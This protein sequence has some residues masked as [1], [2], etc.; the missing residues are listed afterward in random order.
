MKTYNMELRAAGVE[1]TRER[2]LTAAAEI[3]LERY[4]AEQGVGFHLEPS[5]SLLN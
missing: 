4:L 3:F 5:A 1:A 2:I